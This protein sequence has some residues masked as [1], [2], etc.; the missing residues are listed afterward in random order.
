MFNFK[1]IFMYLCP[2][3]FIK[4]VCSSEKKH[5]CLLNSNILI[6]IYLP[7]IHKLTTDW[8]ICLF[9]CPPANSSLITYFCSTN[10]CKA[11]LVMYWLFIKS[12]TLNISKSNSDELVIPAVQ[13]NRCSWLQKKMNYGL[14]TGWESWL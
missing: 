13:F 2:S 10:V 7:P 8:L 14:R 5:T 3:W 11:G 6:A 9:Y 4:L 1:Y 12:L